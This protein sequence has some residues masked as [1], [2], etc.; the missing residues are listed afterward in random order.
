M[1]SINL[2]ADSLATVTCIS[3]NFIDHY[4]SGLNGDELKVYLMLLRCI[5]GTGVVFSVSSAAER[6]GISAGKV[7]TSL[8]RL[9]SAGLVTLGY[10]DE[11]ELCDI[12]ML[13]LST[14]VTEEN[15]GQLSFNLTSD[16][17]VSHASKET[18]S[19]DSVSNS[20][21]KTVAKS[22][23]MSSSEDTN[24]PVSADSDSI[25]GGIPPAAQHDMSSYDLDSD[26]ELSQILFIAERYL[27]KELN[28]NGM[29]MILYW[30]IELGMNEDMIDY[31]ITST[32][33]AGKRSS[34][35]N[36]M[37]YMNKI[38]ISW[39]KQGIHTVKEAMD[40]KKQHS[41]NAL[42]VKKALGVS[43]N[44][45]PAELEYID[46][47]FNQW[48]FSQEMV[49]DACNRTRTSIGTSNWNYVNEILSTWH[50]KGY[51]DL[52]QT[53]EDDRKH[54][55]KIKSRS[56]SGKTQAPKKNCFNSYSEKNDYDSKAIEA[57]LLKNNTF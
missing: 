29:N 47:W 38:A 45:A 21:V 14:E 54:S 37:N 23:I 48:H 41:A 43:G 16:R 34:N 31:L 36:I 50:D 1:A 22:A 28:N 32:L 10:D 52:S 6:L 7:R 55:E 49:V 2:H 8:D 51:T 5:Y 11:G 44:L 26:P 40:E 35:M 18:T 30:H 39:Y 3:N 56:A 25:G 13:P 53:A 46:K 20:A 15:D 33:D 17:P 12:Q 19:F 57:M 27:G 9:S 4:M 42:A 24:S